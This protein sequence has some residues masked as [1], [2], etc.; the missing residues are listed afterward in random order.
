MHELRV[1]DYSAHHVQS[2]GANC[3]AADERDSGGADETGQRENAR[4]R[5]TRSAISGA[6]ASSCT[7]V[8]RGLTY[9][10]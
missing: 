3:A 6:C 4:F 8:I 10:V 5:P 9:N 2:F 1:A 7:K